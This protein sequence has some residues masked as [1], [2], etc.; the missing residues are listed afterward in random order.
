MPRRLT[1][2]PDDDE[3]VGWTADGGRVLFR[4]SRAS[5]APR[6]HRLFTVS[7]DGGFPEPVDLPS[8]YDGAFSHDGERLAWMPTSPAFAAWKRYR[9][10]Q[11]T[12][13]AIASMKDARLET[14]PRDN[15]NDL[16]PMWVGDT[17]YFLSDRDGPVTLFAY[18]TKT[19]AVRRALAN[20]GLLK[21][22]PGPGGI[23]YEQFGTRF[24][25]F[26]TGG[27]RLAISVAADPQAHLITSRW[28]IRSPNGA[29]PPR[30]R[31]VRSARLPGAGYSA[32]LRDIS[33]TTARRSAIP[34]GHRT[35]T[36][37]TPPTRTASTPL[38]CATRPGSARRGSSHWRRA[39][40]H[41]SPVF[42]PT[43]SGSRQPAVALSSTSTRE[44]P[45]H[46]H[47]HL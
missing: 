14:I 20:D 32:Y 3:V 47:R 35:E 42:S 39:R 16:R 26:T 12:S 24:F 31:G 41:Y 44:E 36:T 8:G 6:Y 29:H 18:D 34:T 5:V 11:T 17:I 7:K 33:A 22:P 21:S 38:S 30:A 13:I 9:G 1:H 37:A 40:L 25:T 10:G 4:S 28:T 19:H 46:R 23:V 43:G 27:R 2:H 15:S 45:P